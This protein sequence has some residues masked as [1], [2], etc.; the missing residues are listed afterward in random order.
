M[1]NRPAV[2]DGSLDLNQV[3]A[4]YQSLRKGTAPFADFEKTYRLLLSSD[5]ETAGRLV[6]RLKRPIPRL[7]ADERARKLRL[8]GRYYEGCSHHRLAIRWTQYAHRAFEELGLAQEVYLCRRLLFTSYAHLGKYRKA[9]QVA[10]DSLAEKTLP[11][12]ERA[13]MYTNLGAMEY[14]IHNYAAALEHFLQALELLP[15]STG[16]RAKPAILYNMGNLYVCLN[17]FAEAEENFARSLVLFQELKLLIPKAYVLQAYGYLYT[18]LGQY[19]HATVR[20]KDARRFYSESG[21]HTGAALC[22]VE[23]MRMDLRLNR[24]EEALN[25]VPELVDAFQARGRTAEAGLIY[26]HGIQAAIAIDEFDLAEDY[27]SIAKTLF[28]KEKNHHYLALCTMLHGVLLGRQERH[29]AARSEIGAAASVFKQTGLKEREL[30]CLLHMRNLDE[31]PMNRVTLA[32]VRQLLKNPLSPV[33]RIQALILVSNYWFERGQVKRSVRVLFEAVNAL[34]ECRA[35]I[36]SQHMRD[37]FFEDKTEIYE[38]LIE[39]LFH[40][41][42][43][44]AHHLIF[45]VVELSRSRH[46]TELLSSRE[47]LPPILNRDE[48][49]ILELQKLDLRLSQLNRKLEALS[50]D[51]TVSQV[52]KTTLLASISGVQMEITTVKNRVG[53]EDRL[54]HFYPIEFEP[55]EIKKR[56]APGHLL[57]MYFLT[58]DTLYRIEMDNQGLRTYRVPLY[59]D[60]YGDLNRL[61]HILANNVQSKMQIAL[62]LADRLSTL[63]L[64]RRSSGIHHFT[65]ILHKELQRFP[66]ALLRR[67]GRFLIETATISNCPNLPVFYFA[68][69]VPER[70]FRKP[71]FFFS[72]QADDPAA[73]ERDV[74]FQLYPDAAVYSGL[75]GAKMRHQLYKSDFIH[76]AGHCHFNK[77]QPVKSYLQLAGTRVSLGFFSGFRFRN[78]P[79]INLAACS[80]AWT[81]LSASNEPHGFVIAAFAAG[82]SNLLAGLWDVDDEATGAWMKV[83]Y[84]NLRE[85]LPQAYRAACLATMAT[86]PN[87]YYWS[88][89]CLLGRAE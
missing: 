79:F 67:D 76:F 4:L 84:E 47:D 14:R 19:F 11:D 7:S 36:V 64:P 51:L 15:E 12:D 39:R 59:A 85:G 68:R 40:W 20:L 77:R 49:L 73:G 24:Y 32:R 6:A 37:R 5:M 71:I 56:I 58:A 81:V 48:P 57:V 35:S 82:G 43:P 31:A 63:L 66:L 89:F 70:T 87:P 62:D 3:L 54:G 88:G 44:R 27:L 61:L 30:E 74:L 29:A 60:F 42:D 52:E 86:R 65:F 55:D 46:M 53:H 50:A 75:R 13:K 8:I 22:D 72:D 21:D 33:V 1:G 17:K 9:R 23:L 41:R 34:E 83:F 25:R 26:Y 38:L 45:K 78:R 28:K 10:D 2:G 18:I 80:S 16:G 69:P